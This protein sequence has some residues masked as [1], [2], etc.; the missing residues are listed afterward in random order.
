[1]L[2]FACMG[3]A[4][5]GLPSFVCK[6]PGAGLGLVCASP[7]AADFVAIVCAGVPG[8][9]LTT[10]VRIGLAGEGLAIFCLPCMPCGIGVAGE[11][12]LCAPGFALVPPGVEFD[13]PGF[14]TAGDGVV[15]AGDGA[16]RGV[17]LRG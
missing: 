14:V 4:G 11:G 5:D 12:F 15:S 3:V 6:A 10:L 1:M 13:D 2:F 7:E 17:I 9:G 16:L 8:A